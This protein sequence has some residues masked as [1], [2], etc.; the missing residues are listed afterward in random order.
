MPRSSAISIPYDIRPSKQLERRIILDM[1]LI[2]STFGLPV[3]Q[4]TYVGFGGIKF[5]DFVMFHKYL[6]LKKY[7]SV[8]HDPN[9]IPRCQFNKP[10]SSI[11]IFQGS[12]ADFLT[13][14][15]SAQ[16]HIFWIDYDYGLTPDLRDDLLTIGTKLPENSF[17]F[18]TIDGE[19]GKQLSKLVP[20]QRGQALRDELE[21][22]LGQ[23][24]DG[25]FDDEKF[26]FTAAD[27]L[28]N[29]VRFSFNARPDTKF[30]PIL[31]LLYRDTSWMV[32]IGG[33]LS[34]EKNSS[35]FLKACKT[36]MDFLPLHSNEKFYEL[37]RFNITDAER[38]LLDMASTKSNSKLKLPQNLKNLGFNQSFLRDYK[39][40]IRYIPRYFE[41]FT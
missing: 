5:Y 23:R 27:V 29:I 37:P 38:H 26:R 31:K 35:S 34:S 9:A 2:G 40:L 11:K 3:N 30:F 36:Q 18:L 41:A 4:S 21:D 39:R 15:R 14:F 7:V 17:I 28:L 10:F 16:P 6:G 22:F 1:L 20:S 8:E 12:M 19:P 25:D 13:D 32:T 33:L 24:I